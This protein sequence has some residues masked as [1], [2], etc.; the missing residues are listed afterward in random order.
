MSI[1][2]CIFAQEEKRLGEINFQI[3]VVTYNRIELLK[4]C[5]NALLKQKYPI[6]EIYIINNASTDKTREYLDYVITVDKR[7]KVIHEKENKGGAFGFWKGLQEFESGK[8][9]WAVMID[10][11]AILDGEFLSKIANAIKNNPQVHAFTGT[12]ITNS[13]ISL[14]HRKIRKN[15]WIL[16][17]YKMIPKERYENDFY[18]DIASFCGLV[19]DQYIVN[20]IGLPLQEYFIWQDDAEYSIRIRKITR[21]LNVSKALIYHKENSTENGIFDKIPWKFYYGYRNLVHYTYR[22]GNIL[23]KVLIVMQ[24]LKNIFCNVKKLVFFYNRKEIY[25]YNIKLIIYALK[26]GLYGNLGINEK[27]IRR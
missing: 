14:K 9:D 2:Q 23:S 5:I 24:M 19:V 22:H 3:I 13:K 27:Y 26:D 17:K 20:R 16:Y 11:D 6:K 21:I 25:F 4:E 8:T 12:V 15:R 10:D 7:I 18:L 1:F